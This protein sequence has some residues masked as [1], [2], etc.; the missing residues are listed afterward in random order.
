MTTSEF[1]AESLVRTYLS[2]RSMEPI[3]FRAVVWMAEKRL[4]GGMMPVLDTTMR[5]DID[6]QAG[7][8]QRRGHASQARSEVPAVCALLH[9][10]YVL[11]P[12]MPDLLCATPNRRRARVRSQ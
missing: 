10:A 9:R 1:A 12:P 5:T 2:G 6:N 4:A 11:S 7:A 8:A 3:L